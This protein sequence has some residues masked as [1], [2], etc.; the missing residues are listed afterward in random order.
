VSRAAAAYR[1]LVRRGG[2]MPAA[3]ADPSR[4]DHVEVVEV[5][6]GETVLCENLSPLA[7]RRLVKAL[8][9]DLAELS[10]QEFAG[11]WL[12]LQPQ[13]GAADLELEE[14]GG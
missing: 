7:A 14:R 10:A 13:E 9:R 5:A 4:I 1:L 11:R 6:S 12:A 2:I 3:L 8:R